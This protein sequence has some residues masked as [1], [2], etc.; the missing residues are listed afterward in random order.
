MKKLNFLL[1]VLFLCTQ[2]FAQ[3]YYPLANSL[4]FDGNVQTLHWLR[5]EELRNFAVDDNFGFRYFVESV[6]EQGGHFY[7]DMDL[8]PGYSLNSTQGLDLREDSTAGA[9][10]VKLECIVDINRDGWGDL[11]VREEDRVLWMP[12]IGPGVFDRGVTLVDNLGASAE[13]FLPARGILLFSEQSAKAQQL[14][15]V[16]FRKAGVVPEITRFETRASLYYKGA[17]QQNGLWYAVCVNAE[18]SYLFLPQ[19]KHSKSQEFRSGRIIG[20]FAA[21]DFNK[22]GFMDVLDVKQHDVRLYWGAEEEGFLEAEN[23]LDPVDNAFLDQLLPLAEGQSVGSL[24]ERRQQALDWLDGG[25][26]RILDFNNDQYPDILYYGE[27]F[28]ALINEKGKGFRR[29]IIGG[30][31]DPD[32]FRTLD[33]NNDGMLEMLIDAHSGQYL[34]QMAGEHFQEITLSSIGYENGFSV[35]DMDQDGD[36]DILIF[37]TS[38]MLQWAENIDGQFGSARFFAFRP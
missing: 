6:D 25:Q 5:T 18:G 28:I 13:V 14:V 3:D 2:G 23:L 12:C 8:R 34:I 9:G 15:V 11:L 38:G 21:A 10:H 36:R 1:S 35:A 32:E 37:S 4:G 27:F 31:Y 20:D 29:E 26:L 22:D 7:R 19:G 30:P 16:D 17:C 24:E 33:V